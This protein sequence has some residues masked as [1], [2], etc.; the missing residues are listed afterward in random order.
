MGKINAS[1]QI[2]FE[3]QKKRTCGNK[4]NFYINR[5]LKDDLDIE[6]TAFKGAL[7]PEEALT[8]FSIFDAY[9]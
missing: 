6:F 7:M 2:M 3:N 9:R 4:S 8:S 5:Y 1:D